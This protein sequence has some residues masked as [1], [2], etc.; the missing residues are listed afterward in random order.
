MT[1]RLAVVH[2]WLTGMRGG[3]R[4]LEEVL[5]VAPEATIYTLLHE[6]GTVEGSIVTR[7]DGAPRRIVTS[8]LSELP[9][10]LRRRY[11]TLLPAMPAFALQLRAKLAADRARGK[12]DAV[13][14]ISHA[15]AVWALPRGESAYVLTPLRYAWDLFE[16][17]F[18]KERFGRAG[19]GA[20]AAF[21]A[22]L[23]A[24]DRRAGAR[25]GRL[26]YVSGFVRE[27]VGRCW[28]R[29]DG[30]VLWP[31]VDTDVIADHRPEGTGA[32]GPAPAAG[33]EWLSI[34]ATAP[35]KRL[36]LAVDAFA[37]L[38]RRARDEGHEAPRLRMIAS[39]P[40]GDRKRLR[41]R[42]SERGAAVTIDAPVPREELLA[43]LWNA[44]GLVHPA[45]EDFG[46]VVAEAMA[47]ARPVVVTADSGAKEVV[48]EGDIATLAEVAGEAT[49]DALAGAIERA[50]ARLVTGEGFDAA[51]AQERPRAFGAEAFRE[52]VRA[53]I[54]R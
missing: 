37:E 45:C 50:E 38:A 30:E 20:A 48:G 41:E 40:D 52:G 11:R 49:P 16:L 2:D 24:L 29:T 21:A 15:F 39:G 7:A 1:M 31:P 32:T 17:Y 5:A 33:A 3:E 14:A 54:E 34:G 12:I 25:P 8:G 4:V 43:R 53:L 18:P 9:G 42:A 28:G 47:A 35:N 22:P 13:L 36:E 44:R 26:A 27:R 6:P 51:R 19:R 46:I 23:R 10:P